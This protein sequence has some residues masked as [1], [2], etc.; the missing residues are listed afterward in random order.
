MFQ[1]QERSTHHEAAHPSSHLLG[2][3]RDYFPL[4]ELEHG[5]KSLLALIVDGDRGLSTRPT[6]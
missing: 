4:D 5:I 6:P 2:T 3:L 1:S